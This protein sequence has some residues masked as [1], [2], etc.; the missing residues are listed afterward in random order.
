MDLLNVKYEISYTDKSIGFRNSC[1]PRAFIVPSADVVAKDK[2]LSRLTGTDFH[3]QTTVLL[4]E[5]GKVPAPSAEGLSAT[6]RVYVVDYAPD[7]ILLH[8]ESPSP[9]YLFLSE[10]FYPG[11]KAFVGDQPET[12]LR[13]NYLFRVIPLPAGRHQ[14]RLLFD[15]L[16][17]KLGIVVSGVTASVILGILIFFFLRRRVADA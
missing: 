11:W 15:P 14:I 1:L 16:T 9:A 5:K 6:A 4:E 12:I 10:I 7:R 13:G 3:P 17:I 2:I 8:A